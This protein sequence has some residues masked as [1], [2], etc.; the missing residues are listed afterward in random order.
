MIKAEITS[1]SQKQKKETSEEYQQYVQNLYEWEKKIKEQ[2]KN[3]SKDDSLTT[4]TYPSIRPAGEILFGAAKKPTIVPVLPEK[5]SKVTKSE[6][7]DTSKE[8]S[9]RIKAFDYKSWDKFDVD[10]ALEESDEEI[11]IKAKSVVKSDKDQQQTKPAPI[12]STPFNKPTSMSKQRQPDRKGK[13][14]VRLEQ[15]FQEKET[16]NAFFKNGNYTMA[17]VHYG[18]AME[19]DPKEAVYVINR[20]MAYL[21]LKKWEN[22][23]SDCTSGLRL[24][25]DNPKALWRRGIARRELGKLEE[26]KNDLQV[27]LR[28][29][30]NDRAVKEELD[31]VLKA[32]ELATP[33]KKDTA[34]TIEVPA[35]RRRLSIEEVNFDEDEIEKTDTKKD[36]NI[37]IKNPIVL[38]EKPAP[39]APINVIEFERDWGIQRSDE[40]LY[41]YIK[42]IPPSSYSNLLSNL[43]DADYISR[44]LVILK[45]FYLLHDTVEDIYNVLYNLSCVKR[46]NLVIGLLGKEDKKVLEVLFKALTESFKD[47][48]NGVSKVTRENVLK[49]AE[50]YHVQ[51]LE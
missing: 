35:P 8:K 47:T 42:V 43:L 15:A 34:Q 33:T 28:L 49:L 40:D 1:Q 37:P 36:E 16:G 29:E 18:K 41:H 46:S 27:A 26:A 24:H 14:T 38:S 23:E 6:T 25:P 7:K 2:E 22:A 51:D 10:K 39:K 3:L 45:D 31:K 17:I 48:Q 32:I 44:I 11:P 50:V 4:S 21:K 19:L 20:A 13:K 5:N 9:K 12:T 30:P